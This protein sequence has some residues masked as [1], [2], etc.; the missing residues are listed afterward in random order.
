[1]GNLTMTMPE[2]SARLGHLGLNSDMPDIPAADL[3]VKPLDIFRSH[4]AN[5]VSTTFGCDILLA[6]DSI[7]L[8][9]DLSQGDLELVVPKLKLKDVEASDVLQ[10][11]CCRPFLSY[12]GVKL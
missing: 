8:S 6:Y 3:L 2:L 9:N 5:L 7:R 12:L 10:K 1:M 11:V 4:L